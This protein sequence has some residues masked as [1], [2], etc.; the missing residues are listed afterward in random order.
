MKCEDGNTFTGE[1]HPFD[2]SMPLIAL[3][4]DFARAAMVELIKKQFLSISAREDEN[5]L[6]CVAFDAYALA[7]A[8]MEARE[9]KPEKPKF[10]ES[11]DVKA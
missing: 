7:D 11:I 2:W 10:P 5:T 4:D 8:M 1:D 9:Y 3:R 6:R